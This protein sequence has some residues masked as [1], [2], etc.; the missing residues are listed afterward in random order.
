MSLLNR[1][2]QVYLHLRELVRMA[3]LSKQKLK[4]IVKEC[5]VEL[6]QEGLTSQS[7]PNVRTHSARNNVQEGLTRS[8]ALDNISF[9]QKSEPKNH[10]FEQNINTAVSSLTD[11]P[12][13]ASIFSDTA[14]TTLQE[15]TQAEGRQ[16]P[17]H[18]QGDVA[19]RTM[20]ASDPQNIFGTASDKWAALA[21]SDPKSK[22]N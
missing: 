5:L 4:L 13:M 10:N 20:A 15:Q 1:L 7:T 8:S 12:V 6:L 17:S 11:D 16:M 2:E 21:F 18:A 14:R 9:S 22:N 19:A 3:K